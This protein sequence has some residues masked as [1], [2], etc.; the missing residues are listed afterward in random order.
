MCK[1]YSVNMTIHE[2]DT[3]LSYNIELDA[4]FNFEHQAFKY[5]KDMCIEYCNNLKLKIADKLFD[6]IYHKGNYIIVLPLQGNVPI[7]TY[8]VVQ[9]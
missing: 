6:W 5:A 8:S 1:N 7:I 9:S 3:Q 4:K 2:I